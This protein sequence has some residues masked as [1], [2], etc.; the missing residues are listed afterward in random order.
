MEWGGRGREVVGGHETVELSCD[1]SWLAT[2]AL[3]DGWADYVAVTRT[4]RSTADACAALV[5][6]GALT[7]CVA[8]AASGRSFGDLESESVLSNLVLGLAL[9]LAAYPMAR[10]RPENP[11]GWFLLAGGLGFELSA[12]GRT[13][14]DA[15][16]PDGAT[17]P[18]W[19]V[20]AD[21]ASLGWPVAIAAALPLTLLCFPDG[22]LLGTLWRPFVALTALNLVAFEVLVAAGT[23]TT[24]YAA[25]DGVR[26][27]LQIPWADSPALNTTVVVLTGVVYVAGIVSLIVRYRRA[28]ERTRQQML[29][30]LLA[31]LLLLAGF[32]FSAVTGI[33]DWLETFV[34]ALVPA[35]I[36]VAI[37]RHQLLDITLVVSRSVSYLIL[38]TAIVTSYVI[39]VAGA[40]LVLSAQLPLGPPALATLV[41]VAAFNPMRGFL[42]RR[43]DRMFFGSRRDPVAVVT[44]FGQRLGSVGLAGVLDGLCESMRLPWAQLLADD[45]L[46]ASSGVPDGLAYEHELSVGGASVGI[47]VVGLRRGERALPGADRRLLTLM[48]AS[49]AVAVQAIVAVENLQRARSALVTAR[50]EERRRLGRDLHDEL[51]PMLTGISLQAEAARRLSVT[52]PEEVDLLAAELREQAIAAVECVRTL[53]RGLRPSVLDSLGLIG[54]LKEHATTL[55]PLR[56]AINGDLPALPAA[57][58]VAAYRIATEALTNVVRHADAQRAAVCVQMDND[59]LTMAVIDNGTP[60]NWDDGQ[61]WDEGMGLASMRER[62]AELGGTFAAGPQDDG[63]VVRITLPCGTVSW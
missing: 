15:W 24:T 47:L 17:E 53:A 60:Q 5:A 59:Q 58:E 28:E 16:A 18:G 10:L 35:A 48:A 56:V 25:G 37:L 55:A 12:A 39:I 46:L 3:G 54:A 13:V 27:Y 31:A 8:G 14:L 32:V 43:I 19:R 2:I 1:G 36:A 57:V 22:R 45:V 34:I 21:V 7:A 11:V 23:R 52:R 63:G 42:Q 4:S 30:L 61:N 41:V 49:L 51:G 40:D 44:A 20:I 38:T 50:E 33:S 9:G 6:A 26:G 29:W 62:V